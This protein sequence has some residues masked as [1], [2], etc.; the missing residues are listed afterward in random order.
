MSGRDVADLM[1]ELVSGPG[2]RD[3]HPRYAAL[4]AHGQVVAVEPGL[5]AVLGYDETARA[6]RDIT[7]LVQDEHSHERSYPEWRKHS[8]LRRFTDSMLYTNPPQHTRLRKMVASVFTGRRIAGLRPVVEL[9]TDGLLDRLDVLGARNR[10]VDFMTE[11]AF[12]LPVAVI[13]ALLGVPERDQVWFREVAA[14]TTYALEGTNPDRLARADIATDK[15]TAYFD[16]LIDRR[17]RQPTDD[18]L[19][20]LVA[21]HVAE[22]ELFSYDELLGN[23][24]LLL[25]AGFDTTT[26]LLG[27]GLRIALA[28]P[29][30]GAW[31]RTGDDE[32]AEG[33]VAEVLRMEPP[34]QATSRLASVDLELAGVP[35]SAGDKVLLVLAAANRDPGR[36]PHPD[37][38]DPT[39]P[40]NKPLT[41]GGGIHLCLGAALARLEAKVALPKLLH[42][43]PDLT[44]AGRASVRDRLVVP[45]LERL[46]VVLKRAA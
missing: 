21:I 45:G 24:V 22:P 35:I 10:P 46:P 16:E 26:N 29:H 33:F 15:L 37:R 13:G 12:R 30:F 23:L 28:M 7:L 31:L 19:S 14:E 1:A 38:F 8:S 20:T 39:R 43:F 9:M 25:V 36:Y 44:V 17:R 42:R 3:P 4:R 11:F 6:L 18:L 5:V 27:H 40:D 34:V 2:R 41:F 32:F